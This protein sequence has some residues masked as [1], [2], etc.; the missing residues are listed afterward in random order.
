MGNQIQCYYNIDWKYDTQYGSILIELKLA[1]LL[2]V[3][4]QTGYV[5]LRS[6]DDVPIFKRQKI[7]FR[8]VLVEEERNLQLRCLAWCKCSVS[9]FHNDVP[10]SEKFWWATGQSNFAYKQ[11][12]ATKASKV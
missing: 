3:Q 6:D 11:L 4:I 9:Q 7:N 2:C 12:A 1:C 8:L 10:K 5:D